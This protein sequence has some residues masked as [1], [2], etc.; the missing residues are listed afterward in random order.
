[1]PLSGKACDETLLKH[2]NDKH[3]HPVSPEDLS[4]ESKEAAE[5]L[6]KRKILTIEPKTTRTIKIT[7]KAKKRQRKPKRP[8]KKSLNLPPN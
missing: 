1:M 8:H 4:I 2:L 5:Q 7:P 3:Q 6:K